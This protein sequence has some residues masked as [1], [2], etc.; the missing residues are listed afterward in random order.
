MIL[1]CMLSPLVILQV[2]IGQELRFWISYLTPCLEPLYLLK[3]VP[4]QAVTIRSIHGLEL[5]LLREKQKYI[6]LREL[7]RVEQVA[8]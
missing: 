2:A 8:V 7:L 4:Q 1:L 5:H 6:P 3:I